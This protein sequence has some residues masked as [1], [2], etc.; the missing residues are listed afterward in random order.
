MRKRLRRSL[1][2]SHDQHGLVRTGNRVRRAPRGRSAIDPLAPVETEPM[3]AWL[4]LGASDA[5]LDTR[6]LASYRR[7]GA[8]LM[9]TSNQ[10]AQP[11]D[12][13]L[14]YLTT[15]YKEVRFVARTASESFF[16]TDLEVEGDSPA[17]RAQH[18]TYLTAPVEIEPIPLSDLR[19]ASDSALV[20]QGQSGKYLRPEVI[21]RLQFRAARTAD[22]AELERIIRPPSGDPEL[23]DPSV[24]DLDRW[25]T[26]ASGALGLEATVERYV[27]EPLLR[28]VLEGT[29]LDLVRQFRVGRK[30]VDYAVLR[31]EQPL[32]V[33]EV[34]IAAPAP[35]DGDWTST[36][37]FAQLRGYV[38]DLVVPGLLID[39]HRV[40]LVDRAGSRVLDEIPRRETKVEDITRIR[41]HIL[42]T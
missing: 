30:Q 5:L 15:P 31:D 6:S 2:D 18:W 33:V 34:K 42:D 14:I 26:I 41:M 21:E 1:A 12:L 37:Q 13:A 9:W 4:L 36:K 35:T 7:A 19:R 28:Q 39:S 38:R 29:G 32:A 10:R 23:P 11:G 17:G 8:E 40:L 20:M 25:R 27:V 3:N 16:S 22:Q 24:F